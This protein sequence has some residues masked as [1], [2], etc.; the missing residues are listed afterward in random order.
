MH[1][2]WIIQ[3]ILRNAVR[4]AL[5]ANNVRILRAV[6]AADA[7]MQRRN[8]CNNLVASAICVIVYLQQ[9]LCFDVVC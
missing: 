5:H 7:D 6:P 8:S 4:F 1:H 3:R 2:H 9:R